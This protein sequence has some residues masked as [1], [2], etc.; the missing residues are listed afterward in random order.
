MNEQRCNEI[1]R[2][3]GM[4]R[5]EF[6][7][8]QRSWKHAPRWWGGDAFAEFDPWTRPRTPQTD[9]QMTDDQ[10]IVLF[11]ASNTKDAVSYCQGRSLKNQFVPY[12]LLIDPHKIVSAAPLPSMEF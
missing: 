4:N 7:R 11:Y 12:D 3:F 8:V 5:A 9:L 2:D 1:L 6:E 10:V